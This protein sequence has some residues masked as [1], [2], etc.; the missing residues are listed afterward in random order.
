MNDPI[1]A[2]LAASLERITAAE[3]SPVAR[4][5]HVA[6]MLVAAAMSIVLVSLL[7][8]EPALPARTQVAFIV[9][10][11]IGL[12]WTAYAGWALAHRR[13]LLANLRVVAG[14]LA[15][16]FTS[17]FVLG[18]LGLALA[19]GTTAFYLAAG[20]GAGMLL[21]AIGLLLRAKRHLA[22]L[23]ARY[24][25]LEDQIKAGEA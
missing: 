10:L 16:S 24:R 18:A 9:M 19:T 7:L 11:V 14:R 8:T 15:V 5:G 1:P 20:L 17:V 3:L 23:Q 4:L 12:S 22:N 13:G 2:E 21:L 6:L 25:A